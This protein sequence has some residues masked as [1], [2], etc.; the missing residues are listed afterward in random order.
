MN[1]GWIAISEATRYTAWFL[2]KFRLHP[3]QRLKLC[4]HIALHLNFGFHL[5][6]HIDLVFNLLFHLGLRRVFAIW[7]RFGLAFH[8]VFCFFP[9][10]D[11]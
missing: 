7:F 8:L 9:W 10:G 6:F 2:F 1:E 3:T 11:S 5:K 4:V